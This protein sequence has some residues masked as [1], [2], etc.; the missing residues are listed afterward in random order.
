MTNL[1]ERSEKAWGKQT[2][3]QK[4]GKAECRSMKEH[5]QA[6]KS[7]NKCRRTQMSAGEHRQVQKSTKECGQVEMHRL[8]EENISAKGTQLP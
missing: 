2:K 4:S 3:G 6:Q 5:R 1:G 7:A 8:V